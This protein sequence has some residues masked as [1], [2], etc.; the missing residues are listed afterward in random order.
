MVIFREL[1]ES[2]C[3]FSR[4]K[5]KTYLKCATQHHNFIELVVTTCVFY[6]YYNRTP[7]MSPIIL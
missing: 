5:K 6:N 1:E 2:N 7:N 4:R 3:E